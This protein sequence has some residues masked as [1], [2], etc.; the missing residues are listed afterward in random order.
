M[1]DSGLGVSCC[2]PWDYKEGES[3]R[4]K[5]RER[6]RKKRSRQGWNMIF[7]TFPEIPIILQ[8]LSMQQFQKTE[9][10]GELNWTASH[11]QVLIQANLKHIC[12]VSQR[13]SSWK[14]VL[15]FDQPK[16]EGVPILCSYDL[17]FSIFLNQA[18]STGKCLSHNSLNIGSN[19]KEVTN[20]ADGEKGHRVSVLEGRRLSRREPTSSALTS[21][22]L[23]HEYVLQCKQKHKHTHMNAHPYPRMYAS[24]CNYIY[25][26]CIHKYTVLM[27]ANT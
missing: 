14:K 8:V 9:N 12:T 17:R 15:Q 16:V 21:T 22:N 3:T 5:E 26:F 7:Q 27:H 23:A 11:R 6:K 20:Q 24:M 4:E 1:P 2:L 13:H 18:Y 10:G 19:I 25:R